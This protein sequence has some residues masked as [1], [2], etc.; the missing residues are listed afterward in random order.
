MNT[1]IAN[2]AKLI[3]KYRQVLLFII[4]FFMILMAFFI[5]DINIHHGL[6]VLFPK[7]SPYIATNSYNK[8]QFGFNNP[9]VVDLVLKDCVGGH[10]PYDK[11]NK[12]VNY[13]PMWYQKNKPKQIK[14]TK[15]ICQ[16]SGG[17]WQDKQQDIYQ[18][19]FINLTQNIYQKMINLPHA[20]NA[21]FF[22]ISSQKI[23]HL[24]RDKNSQLNFFRLI[25]TQGINTDDNH[26]ANKQLRHLKLGLEGNPTLSQILLFKKNTQGQ[27][28]NVSE[29]NCIAKGL[30]IIGDYSKDIRQ[31]SSLWFSSI[32]NI[33]NEVK[34]QY[35][36]RVEINILSEHYLL[37]ST[38]NNLIQK[39]WLFLLSVLMIFGA[40]WY[41][42]KN[43][44]SALL[45]LIC[46]TPSIIITLGV[47]GLTQ[48]K[49]T[50]MILLI[51]ILLLAIGV[52]HITHIMRQYLSA[53][54]RAEHSP[55]IQIAE[56]III[57]TFPIIF[58]T[59]VTNIL[60][61]IFLAFVDVSFYKAYAYF[62]IL[63][64]GIILISTS[65]APILMAMLSPKPLTD[66]DQLYKPSK[67]KKLFYSR[68]TYLLTSPLK[69]LPI[70]LI[71]ILSIGSLYQ[72]KLYQINANKIM[73][74]VGLNI[75]YAQ[76]VFK[77]NA[78]VNINLHRLKE[79]MPGVISVNVFVKG[80][81]LLL[82]VCNDV[83]TIICWDEYDDKP[84]GVFNNA[85]ALAAISTTEN[86]MRKHPN[87][88]FTISYAQYIKLRNMLLISP[89]GE[90]LDMSL[91]HIP[92]KQFI[93]DNIVFYSDPD[94]P[95]F[96]PDANDLIIN[97]NGLIKSNIQ[98]N[99]SLLY[100]LNQNYN[101]GLII[102]FINTLNPIK[103]HQTVKD[104]QDFLTKN[105]NKPGFNLIKWGYQS[106]DK[107]LLP[108]SKKTLQ[109][110]HNNV[111][112]IAIGGLAGTM[113]AAYDI[114][115]S[116]WLNLPLK[117]AL[118][119]LLIVAI[120]FKSF[121]IAIILTSTLLM[122]L[123]AQYGLGAYFTSIEN[124][125]G[126]LHFAT[127][128][129]LS[130]SMGIGV[131]YGIY[132]IWRLRKEMVI[133]ANNWRQALQNTFEKTGSIVF[134]SVLI[135]LISLTPLLMTQLA[136]IWALGIFI[137]LALIINIILTI[138][139]I[140]S[141]LYAFKPKYIFQS[142]QL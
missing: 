5:K 120:F 140:P 67:L 138:T 27:R 117:T 49:L 137:S 130:I 87:I 2:Y 35:G 82:P 105:K 60:G 132:I 107:I 23:R 80:K 106:G 46:V 9:M 37:N 128:T 36:D 11:S 103:V 131:N 126:N 48:Y 63:G 19:W 61:F 123:F 81:K 114:A 142:N 95:D 129:S 51:P 28:C 101:E 30:F 139:I 24:G 111:N 43:I 133:T 109:I 99:N 135:S 74:G 96:L 97:I 44:Y 136:N 20:Q 121:I 21:N 55:A 6:D 53:M 77:N 134:F 7:T 125:S 15:E 41:F 110:K 94:D 64:L 31:K 38:L 25:P 57:Q 22:S 17:Q 33:L 65:F 102:G 79:I 56:N 4:A 39:W 108:N 104:I 12:I 18:A 116:V 83:G 16:K 58:L 93:A 115:L 84:Q 66:N 88:S 69:Y 122:A 92:N 141:L 47:M 76:A 75:N 127:L 1:V 42:N 8:E 13:H 45:T 112:T 118:A 100:F 62:G 50:I 40:L 72:T 34:A 26:L 91:F 68:L 70:G 59:I 119:I 54:K 29:V 71:V 124:W 73:P 14:M 113:E 3:I 52:G 90:I 32:T 89:P 78:D 86:W 85:E 10:S 98:E